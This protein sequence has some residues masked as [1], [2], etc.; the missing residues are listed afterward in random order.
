VTPGE[1]KT[2]Q[3]RDRGGLK[4]FTW[5]FM[6]IGVVTVLVGLFNR[7]D[8]MSIAVI[9][10]IT[11]V[12]GYVMWQV[13]SARLVASSE[14]VC[15]F[16]AFSSKRCFLW[17]EILGFRLAHGLVDK[18]SY[19]GEIETTAGNHKIKAIAVNPVFERSVIEG[20]AI[21][22]ELN[23]ELRRRTGRVADEA[24]VPRDEVWFKG[25][26]GKL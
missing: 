5:G 26:L 17:D 12:L 16:E 13:G 23:E 3:T 21:I 20:E 11:T 1:T 7:A 19:F 15:V 8:L 25:R 4:L 9:F 18:R 2:F 6:A 14:G 22:A 10:A 24:H